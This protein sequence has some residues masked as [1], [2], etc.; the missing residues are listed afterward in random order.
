MSTKIPLFQ[1][2]AARLDALRPRLL[3]LAEERG[4]PL[5]VYDADEACSNV[6]SFRDAFLQTGTP[7]SPY[8]AVKSNPYLGLLKTVVKAGAY[9]DVSSP[10]EL[11]L[12]LKAGASRIVY[13]GPAKTRDDLELIL[14]HQDKIF[15]HLDSAHELEVLNSLVKGHLNPYRCGVRI[16]AKAQSKWSKFGIPLS[17]LKEFVHTAKRSSQLQISALQFH[18]SFNTDSSA[19]VDTLQEIGSYLA[20]EFSPGEASEFQTIDIGGG[21]WPAA[22]EGSY[23]W[24]PECIIRNSYKPGLLEAILK[25]EIGERITAYPHTPINKMAAE[26][27]AAFQKYIRPV[28]PH[29]ALWAEPGRFISHSVVHMLLKV[30]D[31]KRDQQL[32]IT[33]GGNNMIGYERY[34]WQDYVPLFNLT[35][36][37]ADSEIPWLIYGSLCTANDLW[38]YYL[39]TTKLEIGDVLVIPFQGAYTNTLAQNFIRAVPEFV[40]LK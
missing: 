18:S 4:T 39:H 38:G 11:D 26:I 31:I 36:F 30:I 13:T 40:D 2:R 3:S 27:G 28:A 20:A 34:Q 7:V 1:E 5:Y 9:L 24:N 16:C 25:D 21:F 29:A 33:D 32:L 14:S 37:S 19:Y 10:L 23:S 15:V 17:H 8:Y 35:H 6:S 22:F 12:A